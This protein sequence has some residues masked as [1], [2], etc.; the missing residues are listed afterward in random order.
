MGKIDNKQG[1][2][3]SFNR[4]WKQNQMKI[5]QVKSTVMER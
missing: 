2:T 5:L 3:G 1:Y 4:K